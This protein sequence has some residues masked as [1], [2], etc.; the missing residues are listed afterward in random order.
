[1]CAHLQELG[2]DILR[3]LQLGVPQLE[4]ADEGLA[5]PA[6]TPAA[7]VAQRIAA[8]AIPRWRR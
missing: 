3:A 4:S 1:M 2:D 7:A 8:A 6:T 5:R